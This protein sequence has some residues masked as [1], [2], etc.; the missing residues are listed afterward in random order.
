MK[1]RRPSPPNASVAE[2]L[3]GVFRQPAQ[4]LWEESH[5]RRKVVRRLSINIT[6]VER[7]FAAHSASPAPSTAT[8]RS[9]RRVGLVILDVIAV[10]TGLDLIVTGA[11]EHC[12][13][14]EFLGYVLRGLRETR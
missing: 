3:H 12:R 8:T 6:R 5:H 11:L 1:E 10:V 9:R 13:L 2:E 7:L 4:S 14:Y